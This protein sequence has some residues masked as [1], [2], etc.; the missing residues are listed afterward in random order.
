[1]KKIT[2]TTDMLK[3]IAKHNADFLQSH[4]VDG[5]SYNRLLQAQSQYF[6]GKPYEAALK[7]DL[8]HSQSANEDTCRVVLLHFPNHD[9]ILTL[10]GEYFY[11]NSSELLRQLEVRDQAIQ[12]SRTLNT[13]WR[14][15]ILPQALSDDDAEDDNN[16]IG[17]A[18]QLG[19]FDHK[20]T[21]LE[22]L[23]DGKEV[24]VH[25]NKS[26][27]GIDSE[28]NENLMGAIEEDS[29]PMDVIVWHVE[30]HHSL[31]GEPIECFF[32]LNDIAKAKPINGN[33]ADWLVTEV[34][35]EKPA[36]VKIINS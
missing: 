25:Q 7:T 12:L 36:Q 14:E 18:A 19:I 21:L 23:M 32:T 20:E 9:P 33:T 3:D 35:K 8:V 13:G 11:G 6:F 31:T 29:N 27:Y 28:M 17:L 30:F 24:L 15:V 34:G 4:G 10:D 26:P 22:Q 5:A 16:I 2:I 1:M